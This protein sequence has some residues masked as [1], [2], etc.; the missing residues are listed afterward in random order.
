MELK[1]FVKNVLL[2][3]IS[4]MDEVEE[5]TVRTVYIA[6]PHDNNNCVMFDIAV[7]TENV[8]KEGTEGVIKVLGV[9]INGEVGKELK[10]ENI[11]RIS[12]GVYISSSNKKQEVEHRDF[13]NKVRAEKFQP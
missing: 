3:L 10:N 13:L 2:D 7:T 4:V 12:F 5:K 6:K 8:M 1:T 9:S 11:S